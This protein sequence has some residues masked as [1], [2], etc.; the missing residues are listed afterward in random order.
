MVERLRG[1]VIWDMNRYVLCCC[2]AAF[3]PTL[4]LAQFSAIGGAS[5]DR[6]T[7]IATD[8]KGNVYVAMTFQGNVDFDK[9]P[10][11]N[12]R[13]SL[14]DSTDPMAVDVAVL[15]YSADLTLQWVITFGSP[16]YDVVRA[17]QIAPNGDVVV[18]GSI[19]GTVYD[20]DPSDTVRALF[21]HAGRDAF[22]A[23]YSSEG[24]YRWAWSFGDA[25]TDPTAEAQFDEAFD[26]DVDAQGNVFLTGA[27]SGEIDL[28]PSVDPTSGIYTS[29]TE[30]MDV[31]FASFAEDG[32]YRW[33]HAVG[34][35]G[36]DEGHGIRVHNGDVIVAG[37]FSAAIDV[38]LSE[39]VHECVSNGGTDAF[40]VRYDSALAVRW[41]TSFGS[42]G[43]DDQ[44]RVGCLDVSASGE[45]SI[46]GVF[47]GSVDIDRGPAVVR[48][49]SKGLNDV[50]YVRYAPDSSIVRSFNVGGA[51]NDRADRLRVDAE[52]SVFLTGGFQTVAD[53][54]PGSGVLSLQAGGVN[55]A[56]NAFI[57]K[58]S[59]DGSVRWATSFGA[60]VSGDEFETEGRGLAVDDING[61]WVTG[62][63]VDAID[64]DPG[65]TKFFLRSS[66]K[67]DAFLL[68]Y[69]PNGG[70]NLGQMTT[71]NDEQGED[72]NLLQRVLR[73]ECHY[74][75]YSVDGR[76]VDATLQQVQRGI[77]YVV[78]QLD[79][80]VRTIP[81]M[82][83]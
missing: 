77:Y 58:Y 76:N 3:L 13:F 31:W 47:G 73:G 79:Q 71:V 65:T 51:G 11:E 53:F 30:A 24:Q 80:G 63:F 83:R 35:I 50:F 12:I 44:V 54:D 78:V 32:S 10:A 25:E 5:I 6:G 36:R 19:G 4:A 1:D 62:S 52:G 18:A 38:D 59:V 43:S 64:I 55:G 14:G 20:L 2:L 29:T 60:A 72:P 57:A 56:Y 23:R 16:G 41:T 39:N 66:G 45:A 49:I 8:A 48:L 75:I 27:F 26:C 67:D 21:G 37:C 61:A 15:K 9:G 40:I 7:D 70:L 34:G 46:S 81:I 69:E 82:I 33:A 22:V 17:L 68:H 74:A 42:A 28:D